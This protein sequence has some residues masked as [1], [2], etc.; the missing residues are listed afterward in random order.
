MGSAA[1][2]LGKMTSY[3]FGIIGMVL[4]GVSLLNCF[5][6][7]QLKRLWIALTGFLLVAAL[8]NRIALFFTSD[9]KIILI[10]TLAVGLLAALLSFRLYLAGVFFYV[11]ILV[12]PVIAGLIGREE[13]WEIAL[14][15]IA[16]LLI[17]LLALNFVRPALILASAIGGGMQAS[18][19]IMKWIS[20]TNPWVLYGVA[21][22]FA[23]A[24]MLVQF[25]SSGNGH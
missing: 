23:L 22:A 4:L 12:Y 20:M 7:Y 25:K 14:A 9:S 6:G 24:G 15:V 21:A 17:G 3:S 16:S 5:L 13:W 19:I 11:A 18:T 8:A 10:V 2:Y 1:W